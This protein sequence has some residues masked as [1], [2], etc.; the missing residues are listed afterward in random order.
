MKI[1]TPIWEGKPTIEQQNYY[2]PTSIVNYLLE[3][4]RPFPNYD[5]THRARNSTF[6]ENPLCYLSP[7]RVMPN[8]NH[9]N[10]ENKLIA[11]II[12]I[13][14]SALARFDLKRAHLLVKYKRAEIMEYFNQPTVDSHL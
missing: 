7:H 13:I 10:A 14:R 3:Q 1:S 12:S 5:V 9:L 2:F 6:H 11:T 8:Y 4:Q